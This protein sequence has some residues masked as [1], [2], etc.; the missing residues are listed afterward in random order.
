MQVIFC[1]QSIDGFIETLG[2]FA[3]SP[4]ALSQGETVLQLSSC[5]GEG[6]LRKISLRPGLDMMVESLMFNERLV[7]QTEYTKQSSKF[8]ISFYVSGGDIA[9]IQGQSQNIEF[10]PGQCGLGFPFGSKG[11][12]EYSAGQKNVFIT[13]YL[14]L[15]VLS[16]LV[17][18]HL[19]ILPEQL[20]QIVLGR[21]QSFYFRPYPVM[22]TMKLAAEQILNCCYEGEIKRLYLEGKA[23][24]IVALHLQQ[25]LSDTQETKKYPTLS[26]DDIERIHQAKEI[27]LQN[28]LEPLSLS[29]LARQIGFNDFKLKWG[30]RKVFG[31][32]VFGYL[33][34]YRL[35]KA[36]HLIA[37]DDLSISE[38]ANAVGFTNHSYFSAIFK[39]KYGINP[40]AY[41]TTIRRQK[42][43]V[44]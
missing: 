34:D 12:M 9:L 40:R 29:E 10:S 28:F 43:P 3:K 26:V 38:I 24:E 14:E 39:R 11:V 2:D 42:L 21:S 20:Q 8:E 30:F 1:N 32:T 27:L 4:P 25:L 15:Q 31:T 18:D 44:T 37:Q 5:I 16:D 33:N 36:K 6:Y 19:K 23:I 17:N 22:P 41:L 13:L 35:S 7:L